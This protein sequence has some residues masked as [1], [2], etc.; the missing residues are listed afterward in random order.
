MFGKRIT[1]FTVFGFA[2]RLDASWLI[3]ASLITWSLATGVFPNEFPG[4]SRGALWLMGLLGALG[5]F[6]SILLHELSHS[7]VA[8]RFGLIMRGITLFVFGGVAEME[9]E[10]PSPKAEFTMA[11]AGPIASILIG[12]LAYGIYRAG[13]GVWP[14]EI[15]GVIHY[16]SWINLVLAGFNL[17]PAFPL[18]GGRVLR[19]LLWHWKHNLRQATQTASA[20]GTGFGLFL[21]VAAVLQLFAGNL[22]SAVWWFLIGLFLRDASRDS[23]RQVMIREALQGEP[24]RRFMKTDL[25]TVQPDISIQELVDNYMYRHHYKMYPVVKDTDK[26]IGCVTASGVKAIPRDHWSEHRVEEILSPCGEQNT[27]GPDT[28]AV[29]ALARMSKTGASR[30]MVVEEGH[31]E[32]IVTLKDLLRFLSLKMDLDGIDGH[33]AG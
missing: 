8:R 32:A 20:I 15:V 27:I 22:I 11:I 2:V 6:A 21:I 16:L 19:A 13:V 10:P 24:V 17:I 5:L 26:L 1:L 29:S 14:V 9:D 18:D 12:V 3:I 28:D 7:L 31:L 4:L 33:P 30:L 25:V 23:Y